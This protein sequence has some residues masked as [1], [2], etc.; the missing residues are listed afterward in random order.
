MRNVIEIAFKKLLGKGR[1]FKT[2]VGFMSDFLDFIVS[3]FSEIKKRIIDLKFTHF[4]TVNIYE[5][6][7]INGEELF[8]IKE[9]EGRTLE[10]RA[11]NV[12]SQWS[13]FAGCQTFKQ[14]ENILRKKGF[15]ISIIENIPQNY[16]TYG[17]RI[18]GN[19]FILTNKGKND[20]VI[21]TNGKHTFIIQSDS[22]YNES[23][24]LNIV[25]A[26]VKNKP[27]H[28]LGFFIPRYLRKKE[29]HQKMT[30]REMQALMKKCYCDCRVE[31]EH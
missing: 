4:P 17:A 21:I 2:P 24:F 15:S 3:P 14:I 13:S 9:T 20:P 16:N 11:A 25:E 23:E 19:G 7:I 12:E 27:G 31:G 26:V 10:E 8:N 1:A 28:N 5:N 22:F 29:I 6:D 30:K 18:I